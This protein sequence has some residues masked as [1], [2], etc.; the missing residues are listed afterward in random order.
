MSSILA[1]LIIL[2]LILLA[3]LTVSQ[4][5]LAS[6]DTLAASWREMES[7]T[8]EQSRTQLNLIDAQ[9]ANGGTLIDLTLRNEGQAKLTDF[10]RWDVVLQYYADGGTY[11][12]D[13]Y[14]YTGGS[15]PGIHHWAVVGIYFDAGLG[16]PEVYDPGIL[17]PGEEMVVRIQVMPPVG[18]G[19][20]NRATLA[21]VNGFTDSI[22]FAR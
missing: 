15:F 20:I 17:D 18:S 14:P 9:T 21:T 5:F 2:T 16:T 8:E 13:W 4:A 12:T 22:D 11:I 10:D 1:G 6:Q 19:T 7:R 3:I